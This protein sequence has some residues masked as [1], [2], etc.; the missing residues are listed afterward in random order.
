MNCR[1]ATFSCP[2]KS[3]GPS[4]SESGYD[5][6]K[7]SEYLAYR[8][9]AWTHLYRDTFAEV[10]GSGVVGTPLIWVHA[11]MLT[12]GDSFRARSTTTSDR[13]IPAPI[14]IK[15]ALPPPNPKYPPPPKA[16]NFMDTGFP[17]ERTHFFQ[18]PIKL[19]QAFPAPELRTRILRTR[20]FSERDRNLQFRGVKLCT[21]WPTIKAPSLSTLVTSRPLHLLFFVFSC[22]VVSFSLNYLLC[23]LS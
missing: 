20:N 19:A 4:G 11:K 21:S 9:C 16:K 3:L 5:S 15:S 8:P 12:S 7:V 23:I 13:K 6:L 1:L 17:G 22:C 10:L 14:K 18:A 2:Q